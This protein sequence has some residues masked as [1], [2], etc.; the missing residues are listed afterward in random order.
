MR[1]IVTGILIICF[2]FLYEVSSA[3]L[4]KKD[5]KELENQTTEFYNYQ[6]YINAL[7]GY[8]KLLEFD[9]LNVEYNHRIA[10][11]YLNTEIDRKKAVPYLEFVVAQEKFDQSAWYDLG[12][13]YM[14]TYRFD[15]AISCF[16]KYQINVGKENYYLS[17]VR[18]MEM[19]EN[20]KILVQD[21]LNV[22][23]ENLG[24]KVNSPYPDFN[25]FVPRDESFVVFT[26]KRSKNMG[27]WT[28]FDGY[29]L[30]DVYSSDY[31]NG[32][33]TEAKSLSSQINSVLVEEVVGLTPDGQ[34]IFIYM[35]NMTAFTDVYYAEMGRRSFGKAE[36]FGKGI[37]SSKLETSATMSRNKRHLFFSRDMGEGNGKMDL[38]MS[39]KLPTGEWSEPEN[40]GSV[41]NTPYD[42]DY[43]VM[44][45]DGKT[46]YFASQGH[47][48]MGGFDIFKTE[49]NQEENSFSPPEN[50]GFPVNSP[51]NEYSICFTESGRHAY[52]SALRDD[53]YGCRDI[54]RL[55]FPDVEMHVN[56]VRGQILNSDSL[57]LY[58]ENARIKTDL[59]SLKYIIDSLFSPKMS[60][61]DSAKIM[62]THYTTLE[63]YRNL[64]EVYLPKMDIWIKAIDKNTETEAGIYRPNTQSGVYVMIL[65]PGDY[66]LEYYFNE[67]PPKS[68]DYHFPDHE[69]AQENIFLNIVLP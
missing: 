46:L 44:S 37:N 22:V 61:A 18:Q 32:N 8:K 15:E 52:M 24:E 63:E 5:K 19:C 21:T 10:I 62:E 16:K 9:S 65:P 64:R 26:S 17:S 6:N 58:E 2:S 27:N 28:D 30:S 4:S 47:K 42:E 25:P 12:E 51:E 48:S 69:S 50:I 1:F 38:F 7:H 43:P 57:N 14:L 40:L 31:K 49:W 68:I 33:W 54:Y 53:S 29:P 55:I 36:S 20:A 35:D 13:A 34:M 11:C 45:P 41:V 60:S 3:Q 67:Q 23:F 39:R 56:V 66:R 59:D